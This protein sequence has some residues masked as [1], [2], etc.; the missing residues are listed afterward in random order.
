MMISKYAKMENHFRRW[1][2]L[3]TEAVHPFRLYHG[4][5][6]ERLYD[7]LDSN[8]LAANTA[9]RLDAPAAKDRGFRATD[10]D[11]RGY[12]HG[13]SLTRN[14]RFAERWQSRATAGHQVLL[15][16][17]GDAIKRRFR[18][19]PVAFFG[20]RNIGLPASGPSASDESEEFVVGSIKP[21]NAFLIEI[22]MSRQAYE[23]DADILDF[24]AKE[25]AVKITI[26]T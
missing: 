10:A 22:R 12:V 19:L 6:L 3:I 20:G 4:T 1:M 15:V 7:I 17:D 26:A 24:A 18:T 9:H 21:L 2:T 5:A 23:Q 8:Q 16:L 25:Y 11:D 13:V 14:P